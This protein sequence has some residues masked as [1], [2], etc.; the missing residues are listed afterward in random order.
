MLIVCRGQKMSIRGDGVNKKR[1]RSYIF[2][3]II[4]FSILIVAVILIIC[5]ILSQSNK[6][7]DEPTS[8][9][10]K[11][12]ID[13]LD[14]DN[15]NLEC[16]KMFIDSEIYLECENLGEL[17]DKCLYSAAYYNDDNSLCLLISDNLFR[18]KCENEIFIIG[19]I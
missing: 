6:I 2:W 3:M 7:D 13:C 5:V 10:S 19:E 15:L 12:L 1:G 17:R 9:A 11:K 4:I 8:Q 16:Q 18:T 14:K